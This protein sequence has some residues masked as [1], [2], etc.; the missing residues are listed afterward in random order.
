MTCWK[1]TNSSY[2]TAKRSSCHGCNCPTDGCLKSRSRHYREWPAFP[3]R[4]GLWTGHWAWKNLQ[5][6]MKQALMGKPTI[7]ASIMNDKGILHTAQVTPQMGMA[8]LA[9]CYT[10]H[11]ILWQITPIRWLISQLNRYISHVRH[12]RSNMVY[13][14]NMASIVLPCYAYHKI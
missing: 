14:N 7:P 13:Q 12:N 2:P 9:I 5:T 3:L 10:Y 1:E 6:C 11:T 4:N 8:K